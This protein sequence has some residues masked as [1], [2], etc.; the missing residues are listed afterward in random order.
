M[1]QGG[2]S[3]SRIADGFPDL[4]NFAIFH[5]HQEFVFVYCQISDLVPY[6]GTRRLFAKVSKCLWLGWLFWCHEEVPDVLINKVILVFEDIQCRHEL[7]CVMFII[8]FCCF[9]CLSFLFVF[10]F[11]DFNG[12]FLLLICLLD[13]YK[14]FSYCLLGLQTA[15]S[16]DEFHKTGS[17]L[18][19]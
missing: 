7:L 11:F 13:L 3:C 9:S 15:F 5:G 14:F 8:I 4:V 17:F 2:N 6:S 1:L 12:L 10:H 18:Q 16:G 19:G